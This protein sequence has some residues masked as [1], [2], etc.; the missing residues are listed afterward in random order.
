MASKKE[1]RPEW[2]DKVSLGW[3]IQHM[4]I[5]AWVAIA[6]IVGGA[7]TFGQQV[8]EFFGTR[9]VQP[10][11]TPTQAQVSEPG[12]VTTSEP[13]EQ[14]A[15]TNVS[16]I[17]GLFA[18]GDPFP[19]HFRGY[20]FGTKMSVFLAAFPSAE[21]SDGISDRLRIDFPEGQPFG[22]AYYSF[23][24]DRIDP[25]AKSVAF[26]VRRDES[27]RTDANAAAEVWREVLG[28]FQSFD[29][30]ESKIDKIIYWDNVNGYKLTL[31]DHN[32]RVR[33]AN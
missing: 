30:E 19:K 11:S 24:D 2:P 14:N 32:F 5:S 22:Y 13:M 12:P 26:Y 18:P 25:V 21:R 23:D 15:T 9:T 20:K 29:Y 6:V 1:Q 3:L 27:Y 8:D 17:G 4:P 16:A 31:T 7:F 10:K 33:Q 28:N